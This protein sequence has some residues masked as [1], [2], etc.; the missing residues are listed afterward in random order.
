[1]ELTHPSGHHTCNTFSNPRFVCKLQEKQPASELFKLA[2]KAF[3]FFFLSR[4][5]P[6]KGQEIMKAKNAQIG[7]CSTL[8]GDTGQVRG[9]GI[10]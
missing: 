6:I 10:K 4:K 2:L 9:Q 8:E 3:P 7:L 1:M 5:G